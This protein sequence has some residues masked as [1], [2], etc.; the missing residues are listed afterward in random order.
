MQATATVPELSRRLGANA[1]SLVRTSPANAR[2]TAAVV[3]LPHAPVKEIIAL[4]QKAGC[5][6]LY[7][8]DSQHLLGVD[9]PVGLLDRLARLDGVTYV[10]VEYSLQPS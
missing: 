4:L 3:L 10:E 9:A 1:R 5:E 6:M 2:V 7:R 8:V